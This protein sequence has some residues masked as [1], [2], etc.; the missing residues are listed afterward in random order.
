MTSE[1]AVVIAMR[2]RQAKESTERYKAGQHLSILDGIP[3]AVKDAM[4]ALPY[5]ST[6]GT[7]Y[8]AER[9]T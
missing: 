8:V 7:A 5:T 3:M 2:C 1:E 6:A 9:Y 4:D